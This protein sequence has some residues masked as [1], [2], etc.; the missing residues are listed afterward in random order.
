MESYNVDRNSDGTISILISYNANIHNQNLTV[1]FSPSLSGS[2]AL[3][4]IIP[5]QSTFAI[6][7]HDNEM[8]Y[9]YDVYVYQLAMAV[10]V[11]VNI[12]AV[13]G[14][15]VFTVGIYVGKLIAV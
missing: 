15:F 12:A 5:L 3:S 2:I 1:S 14:L 9:F 4:K 7:P 13:T 10:Y 11:M 8:A 6:L